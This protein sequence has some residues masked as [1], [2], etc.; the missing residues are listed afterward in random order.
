MG[1]AD[2]GWDLERA[3]GIEPTASCL[4]SQALLAA[5]QA[6]SPYLAYVH[7]PDEADGRQI[8]YRPYHTAIHAKSRPI[9]AQVPLLPRD[10]Q[11][12]A[13]LKFGTRRPRVSP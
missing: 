7:Q 4:G 11:P 10:D 1:V 13:D 3:M 9:V 5:L 2:I 8:D 6:P 12:A